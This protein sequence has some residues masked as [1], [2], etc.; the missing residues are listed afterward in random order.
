[1]KLPRPDLTIFLYMPYSVAMKL[2]EGRETIADGHESN[3]EHLKN[4]EE[5]YLQLAR[6]YNWR[7][8]DCVPWG[9]ACFLKTVD[10]IHD[11]VYQIT[12]GR[13]EEV[14]KS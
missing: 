9:G 7:R 2:K 12:K 6:L 4:A 8:I 3:P 10:E 11:E 1:M 5:A 14:L 13:I